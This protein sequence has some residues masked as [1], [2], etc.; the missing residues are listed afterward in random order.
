MFNAFLSD[1]ERMRSV[2][3]HRLPQPNTLDCKTNTDDKR[4]SPSCRPNPASGAAS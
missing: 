1:H 2:D 3:L 4:V